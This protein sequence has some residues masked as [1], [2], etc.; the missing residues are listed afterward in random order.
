VAAPAGVGTLWRLGRLKMLA[1]TRYAR[2]Q[3][4]P[5]AD[6]PK[7]FGG[8]APCVVKVE[9]WQSRREANANANKCKWAGA[10][11][12][13]RTDRQMDGCSTDRLG[14]HRAR[15]DANDANDVNTAGG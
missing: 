14:F 1:W 12:G 7:Q 15:I 10:Q 9:I 3:I 6:I 11:K 8:G 4:G 2:D 13:T 5:W